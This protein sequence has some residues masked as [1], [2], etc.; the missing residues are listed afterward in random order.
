MNRQSGELAQKNMALGIISK[1][2]GTERARSLQFL[3]RGPS[4]L[5]T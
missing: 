3:V 5:T 4:D 2:N 1:T